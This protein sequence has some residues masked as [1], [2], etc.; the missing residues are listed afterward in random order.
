[1]TKRLGRMQNNP[2]QLNNPDEVTVNDRTYNIVTFGCQMNVNES[3]WLERGLKR[4]GFTPAPEDS[5]RVHI[6]NTCS[7]RAKPVQKV[8]SLLG[9]IEKLTNADPDVLVAVGGCVAQQVGEQFFKRF[10]Q[11]RLVFGPDGTANAPAAL[12]RLLAEPGLK[13]SLL[14]FSA[15][16]VD[17]EPLLNGP[18]PTS[19]YVDIM[20]GCDNF[21]TY[22]IVPFTR[23][24]KKSR[25]K[26]SVLAECRTLVEQGSREITL[27]GQNVNAY[28]LD[29]PDWN[30]SFAELLYE[31]AAIPGLLRLRFMTSHPKDIAPEVI[32]AFKDLPNLCPRLHLPLQSG[33]NRVLE[34]MNRG[35]TVE[36]Y[37][38]IVSALREARP[39]LELSTDI[40]VG[41][42][43]ETEADFEATMLAMQ[44]ARFIDS[45]SFCYSDRPGTKSERFLDKVSSS[46]ALDRLARLQA[47]QTNQREAFLKSQVGKQTYM[48]VESP[49]KRNNGWQG[50]DPYGH[51]V[52]IVSEQALPGRLLPVT[53]IEAKKHS[54]IAKEAL[55]D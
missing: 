14:D 5:A 54:L 7:V 15:E 24:P 25:P 11:V 46:V 42:P 30:I 13:L 28:A 29:Q 4:A 44:N 45:F 52:N 33:S 55:N 38:E 53:I 50:R 6:L 8:M 20:Q 18:A 16:Y 19:A 26:Q 51:I 43:G 27:L 34:R 48:L 31:V 23:G 3:A 12:E 9:R 32:D 40:I 22:C 10:P 39:E 35:Y 2:L 41:F 37:L 49:S 36:R 17:K 1:M 47:W 21:C